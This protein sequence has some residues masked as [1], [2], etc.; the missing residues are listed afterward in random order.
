[1]MQKRQRHARESE[2]AVVAR[3]PNRRAED[4]APTN[5]WLVLRHVY[6]GPPSAT[7]ASRCPC[8]ARPLMLARSREGEEGEADLTVDS[9]HVTERRL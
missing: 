8:H 2:R 3:M 9:E 4:T 1:M 5:G 6:K 7:T